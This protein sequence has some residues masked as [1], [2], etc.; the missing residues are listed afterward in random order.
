MHRELY[1]LLG[2]SNTAS[3]DDIRKAWR[4][5]LKTDHPDKG[6]DEEKFK[7][8]KMAY[9]VLFDPAQRAIY[10]RGGLEALKHNSGGSGRGRADMFAS[11]FGRRSR[12]QNVG[13]KKGKSTTHKI[14]ATL[15]DLYNGKRFQM[16][17]HRKIIAKRGENKPVH[18]DKLDIICNKCKACGGSGSIAQVRKM[19]P[20]IQQFHSK[21]AP[22]NGAG[23]L[24]K[25]EY[26]VI[27]YKEIIE[28]VVEKGMQHGSKIVLMNKTD[29]VVGQIP[30][31]LI[32][33]I[34]ESKHDMYKRKNSD[35]FITKHLTMV[36]SLCGFKFVHTHLDGRKFLI[37]SENGH[38]YMNDEIFCVEEGGMP[39]LGTPYNAGRLFIQFKIDMP[40]ASLVT[41]ENKKILR[42]IFPSLDS[43]VIK[44]A[45]N[46]EIIKLK[47][48]KLDSFGKNIESSK[49]VYEEDTNNNNNN[50]GCSQQ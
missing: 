34:I 1:D 42:S 50:A 28:I 27:I 44:D 45:F 20:I 30:G 13:P 26:Q 11:F 19:G 39:L 12:Q 40:D 48:A 32:F 35:L 29:M 23:F 47:A 41:E 14:K 49:S 31:D 36:E 38:M 15:R 7:T 16:R 18:V 3:K 24:L 5:K 22:C 25:S 37:A 4:S 8:L 10:D 17:I 2:V 43:P 9:E 6:G 21:C 33:E 46:L